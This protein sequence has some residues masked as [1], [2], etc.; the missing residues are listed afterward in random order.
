MTVCRRTLLADVGPIAA[1][2]QLSRS[3]RRP[4]E[5]AATSADPAKERR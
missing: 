5:L 3:W 1:T 2:R 4:G